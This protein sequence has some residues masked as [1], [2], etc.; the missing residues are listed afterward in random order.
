[1]SIAVRPRPPM[2]EVPRRS[3]QRRAPRRDGAVAAISLRAR[4][5]QLALGILWLLD[6]LLQLQPSMFSR[7]FVTTVLLPSAADNPGFVAGPISAA[8]RLLAPHIVVFNALF[9]AVQLGIGIAL[10]SGRQVRAALAT[11]LA[12]SL[13]VWWLG[14]GFGGLLGGAAS[15]ISGAPGA[16][17]LYGIA[18]LL[19]WPPR[20]SALAD[21]VGVFSVRAARAVVGLVWVLGAA[22]LLQPANLAA[23]ALSS[24]LVAGAAG[25]PAWLA[26][27]VRALA[28]LLGSRGTPV[29]LAL[30]VTML[31]VAI[32]LGTGRYLGAVIP[33]AVALALGIWWFG[34][35]LGGIA[36]GSATDPNSAPL[37]ILLTLAVSGAPSPRQGAPA[38]DLGVA[39]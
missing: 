7:A 27:P 35:G 5:I 39:R 8:A 19:A 13:G 4:R 29:T 38:L 21:S 36:T 30:I 24:Q 10:V 26:A 23:H 11:S 32:G 33:L 17:A 22:L 34:Q 18:A 12:W 1:M 14:E 16:V 37:L 28:R 20:R 6:G 15:P 3:L 2:S 9:A 31:A 25:E